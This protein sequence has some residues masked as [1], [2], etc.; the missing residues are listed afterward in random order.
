MAARRCVDCNLNYPTTLIVPGTD[1]CFACKE[2]TQFYSNLSPH[3]DWKQQVEAAKLKL[4]ESEP[5][6]LIP[7]AVGE[8]GIYGD[9][10]QF[11]VSDWDLR[12]AKLI[13]PSTDRRMF[14]FQVGEHYWEAQGWDEPR[15]RWWVAPVDAAELDSLPTASKV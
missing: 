13:P 5:G 1:Y 15:R 4:K 8:L 7:E 11:F 12:Q 9:A 3:A 2:P 6:A 14:L 10:G